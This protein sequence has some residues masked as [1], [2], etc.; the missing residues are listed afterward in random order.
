M[1]LHPSIVFTNDTL[2]ATASF[3]GGDDSRPEPGTY[4]WH[5]V[6]SETGIDAEVQSGSDNTLSG[7]LLRPDDTVY[8]VVTPTDGGVDGPR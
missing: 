4:A 6:D 1:T 5:V 7:E 3:F 2:T 8:V